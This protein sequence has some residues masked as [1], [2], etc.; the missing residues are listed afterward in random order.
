[1]KSLEI[2]ATGVSPRVLLDKQNNI[3]EIYGKSLQPDTESFYQPVLGWLDEYA[4]HPNHDMTFVFNLKYYNLT[5]AKYF[6]FMVYKLNEIRQQG[7]H[8]HVIWYYSAHDEY[9]KEFGEDLASL[10]Q[11]TFTLTAYEVFEKRLAG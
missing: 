5:S 2:G 9:M 6:M 10:Y 8:V 3:F 1:M 4:L 11:L 7:H